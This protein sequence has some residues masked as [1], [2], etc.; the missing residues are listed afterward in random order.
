MRTDGNAWLFDQIETMVCDPDDPEDVLK[1]NADRDTG[2]GG[3]DGFDCLRYGLASRPQK[4]RPAS[5]DEPFNAWS[6]EALKYEYEKTHRHTGRLK[7]RD[8]IED[9]GID[10]PD[11]LFF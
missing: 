2:E 6:P 4:A 8:R 9:L 10:D 7:P 3:D 1:V 11:G 5:D